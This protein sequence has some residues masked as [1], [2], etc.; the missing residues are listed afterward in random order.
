MAISEKHK[1]VNVS[2]FNTGDLVEGDKGRIAYGV[3]ALDT[4]ANTF[5]GVVVYNARS[6]P[7]IGKKVDGLP[8]GAE[9]AVLVALDVPA[10]VV[11]EARQGLLR[12]RVEALLDLPCAMHEVMQEVQPIEVGILSVRGLDGL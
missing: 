3:V 4:G 7:T 12:Q 1:V 11:P 10:V 8:V 6:T 5:D 2:N 9:P